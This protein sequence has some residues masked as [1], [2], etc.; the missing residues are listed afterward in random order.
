MDWLSFIL[1]IFIGEFGLVI[2]LI[3]CAIGSRKEK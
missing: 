1:G 3:L 2:I